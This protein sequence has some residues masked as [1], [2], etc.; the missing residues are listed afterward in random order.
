MGHGYGRLEWGQRELLNLND[1]G[2]R[3][4]EILTYFVVVVNYRLM[5]MVAE[6]LEV[7]GGVCP[8]ST[9]GSSFLLGVDDIL[10]EMG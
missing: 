10:F 7:L 5:V 9:T 1:G 3:V 8:P 4:H 6:V 2:R